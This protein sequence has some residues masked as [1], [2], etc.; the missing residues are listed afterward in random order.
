MEINSNEKCESFEPTDS[1][2]MSLTFFTEVNYEISVIVTLNSMQKNMKMKIFVKSDIIATTN[3]RNSP[4]EDIPAKKEFELSAELNDLVP[5]CYSE[6]IVV[7][8]DGFGY[9]DAAVIV[10]I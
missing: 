3:I 5:N 10:S 6:W 8:E 7:K 4:V 1:S 9:F 2:S